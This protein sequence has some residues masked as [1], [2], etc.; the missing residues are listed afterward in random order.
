MTTPFTI[1]RH[2]TLPQLVVTVINAATGEPEDFTDVASVSFL[3]STDSE[4]RVAKVDA[5]AFVVLPGTGG[6]LM[7]TFT[8]A[9]TDTA[10]DYLAEF[11]VTFL[12]GSRV[13]A[14][15]NDYIRVRV[16]ADLDDA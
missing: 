6:T 12:D 10:G 4:P 11:V 3:M 8:A 15:H 9:D 7:Y 16:V 1:K 5:G 14:P 13:T 2:D